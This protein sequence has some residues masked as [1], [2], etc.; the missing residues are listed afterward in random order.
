MGIEGIGLVTTNSPTS[1]RTGA[2]DSSQESSATPRNGA[3]SSPGHTATVGTPP[4]NAD[5]TSVPPLIEATCTPM[6]S[7][8]HFDDEAGRDEPVMPMLRSA[9]RSWVCAGR[10]SALM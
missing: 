4:M 8:N 10:A 1:P 5:T 6:L 2:P 3:E 9:D 7:A